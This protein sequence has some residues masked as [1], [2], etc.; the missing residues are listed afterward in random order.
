M[1]TASGLCWRHVRAFLFWHEGGFVVQ[2]GLSHW[3]V[4]VSGGG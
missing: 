1:L 3:V 2:S 4:S